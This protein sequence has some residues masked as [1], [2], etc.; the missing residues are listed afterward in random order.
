[1]DC[2]DPEGGSWELDAD[3]GS[4]EM[5]RLE[6][7]ES[8][9]NDPQY[10]LETKRRSK[11]TMRLSATVRSD[12]EGPENDLQYQLET[13]RGST[14]KMRLSATVRS[15]LEGPQNDPQYQLET[16]GGSKEKTRLSATFRAGA[17]DTQQRRMEYQKTHQ[18]A[19]DVY[20]EHREADEI[21][22]ASEASIPDELLAPA[23]KVRARPGGGR[24]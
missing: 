11:E 7:R 15:D 14:E 8:S 23:G 18:M 13:R 1:M 4:A 6:T 22:I 5:Y 10:Q 19:E 16:R 3:R 9:E 21:S 17:E 24:R 20:R 2:D 12:L